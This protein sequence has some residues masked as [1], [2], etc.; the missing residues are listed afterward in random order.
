MLMT[1]RNVKWIAAA[2]TAVVIA[3]LAGC[4][5]DDANPVPAA[6]TPSGAVPF[7]IFAN[8]AFSNSANSTPVAIN[9][10][11]F[12]FDVNDQPTYF[13][14]LIAMGTYQ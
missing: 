10:V 13:S 7:S 1:Y 14:G 8:Q 5:G 9:N 4:G 2:A 6:S 3:A 11:N 12:T